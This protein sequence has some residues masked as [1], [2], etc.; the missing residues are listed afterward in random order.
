MSVVDAYLYRLADGSIIQRVI[1]DPASV[2][3]MLN[4]ST[5]GVPYV[6]G[7]SNDT[8]KVNLATLAV[9]PIEP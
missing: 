5:G 9:E 6:P 3:A 2:A 4:A 1:G 8:H 7:T